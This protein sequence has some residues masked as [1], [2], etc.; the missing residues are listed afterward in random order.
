MT[1]PKPF[2][3]WAGGKRKLVPKL[4]EYV[5]ADM[6]RYVEPFVGGGALFFALRADG[7]AGPALLCDVNSDL[8]NAYRVVR[9]DPE[10][11]IAAL[12]EYADTKE[13]FLAARAAHPA[14]LSRVDAA[15]RFIFLNKTCFNGLH[16]VNKR[17]QFNV[18]YDG[19]G[20][21]RTICDEP[22]IMAASKALQNTDLL[23][24]V[25]HEVV[26][27]RDDF[28]YCDPPYIPASDS[29]DFT[30]YSAGWFDDIDQQHLAV[31]ARRW[32]DA[33]ATVVI[34]NADVPRAREL[35]SGMRIES[36]QMKRSINS[37]AGKR[38]AVGEI[39]AYVE[40]ATSRG[41]LAL[42]DGR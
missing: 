15:A 42:G 5:P 18:P 16:R 17:G 14:F 11:L 21:A 27:G 9:D 40:P 28:I 25:F 6:K 34:S 12:R 35:Y 31:L 29:A 19:S 20:T 13:Q 41:A 23:T 24:Q 22:T 2:L 1:A 32:S 8:M 37:K 4:L 38:G 36:V 39:V 33:G 3:K 7:Y 30:A 10:G 26:A